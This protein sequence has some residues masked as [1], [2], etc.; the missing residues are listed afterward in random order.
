MK[1]GVVGAS[2]AGG[3]F[4]HL[5]ASHGFAVHLFDPRA[6]WEKPCG[7]GITGK[8]MATLARLPAIASRAEAITD[9][10]LAA[11]SG[12]R[13]AFTTDA[14]L[15]LLPRIELG[16]SLVQA[17]IDAGATLV[18]EKVRR[19][20][21]EVDGSWSLS[22]QGGTYH[23]YDHLV[24]ADGAVSTVRRAVDRPFA[25]DDLI[26]A[27]DYHLDEPDTRPRVALEFLGG[28]MGY[29][30]LF[31]AR[32]YASVGIG[33]PASGSQPLSLKQTLDDFLA[34]EWPGAA[35]DE[36][37]VRRWVIPFHRK[38]FDTRYRIQGQGWSL[39]GDAAGL[40]DPLT[41]EGIYYAVRS[42]E[43][44]ADALAAGR[45][46]DFGAAVEQELRPELAKA[47]NIGR[48]YF[49]PRTLDVLVRL[50]RRSPSL[51]AFLGDY[52][53]GNGSY[54]TAR[55]SLKRRGWQIAGDVASSVVRGWVRREG[56][57]EGRAAVIPKKAP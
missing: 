54:L 22:T 28:G 57:G 50:A 41:G 4:A 26:V 55:R 21:Q 47:F 49:R 5:A 8:A 39:L 30:W 37:H 42:A 45:P 43:L 52:L 14:P 13:A 24:G 53:T 34:R 10:A 20:M 15:Y 19:V 1:V 17:A 6:P 35:I 44:L 56:R 16:H 12:E 51:C 29:L 31:A 48:D 18:P 7:G 25:R 2:I 3:Y 11:P 9:F 36:A 46:A 40:A 23:G 33:L 38:G 32:R 27:L